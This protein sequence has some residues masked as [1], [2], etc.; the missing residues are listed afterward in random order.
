MQS[1]TKF[2][3][4]LK[5]D[6]DVLRYRDSQ[7][8]RNACRLVATEAVA[9]I[10]RAARRD[11]VPG[12]SAKQPKFELKEIYMKLNELLRR[13]LG[14]ANVLLSGSLLAVLCLLVVGPRTGSAQTSKGILAGVV[15]DS[16]GAVVQNADVT[17]TNEATNETRAVTTNSSGGYRVEAINPGPYQIHINMAGFT[18]VDVKG[19]NVQPSVVTTYD[20]TLTLGKSEVT[21]LVEANGNTINTDNAQLSGAIATTELQQV[22]SLP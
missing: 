18:A 13:G 20:A 10:K 1:I 9:A 15:R 12:R 21:L 22:P 14:I 19:I 5:M 6:S 7:A 4:S 16:T 2:W 17:I 11:R 8:Q 3:R